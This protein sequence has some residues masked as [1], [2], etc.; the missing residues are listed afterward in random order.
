MIHF[1]LLLAVSP[2]MDADV[3]A[4]HLLAYSLLAED[5]I[6]APT[7]SPSPGDDGDLRRAEQEIEAAGAKAS[8]LESTLVKVIDGV[9][10]KQYAKAGIGPGDIKQIGDGVK[11]LNAA[12]EALR[13]PRMMETLS[14]ADPAPVC[15]F[16]TADWCEPCKAA[17]ADL[18]LLDAEDRQRVQ[19]IN[20][21]PDLPLPNPHVQKVFDAIKGKDGTIQIPFYAVADADGKVLAKHSGGMLVGTLTAWLR[22]NK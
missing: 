1:A 16:F 20:I 6:P 19:V 11:S 3:E 8:W 10:E 14:L 18:A 2:N 22:K 17:R 15:Y 12:M 4:A 21:D 13:K 7:P 5:N 9:A